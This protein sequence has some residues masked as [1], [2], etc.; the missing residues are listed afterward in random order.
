LEAGILGLT[1]PTGYQ[2]PAVIHEMPR[3][4]YQPLPYILVNQITLEQ[5]KTQIGQDFPS[6]QRTPAGTAIQTLAILARRTF[7]V[8]I[9]CR[10]AGERE[11]YRDAV[12]AILQSMLASVFQSLQ[13]DTNHSFIVHSDQMVGGDMDPGFYF[14]DILFKIEGIYNVTLQPSFNIIN[15]IVANVGLNAG[16]INNLVPAFS[17]PESITESILVAQSGLPDFTSPN[18]TNP[19]ELFTTTQTIPSSGYT[20]PAGDTLTIL[21]II[22][23][24]Y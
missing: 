1:L 12:L 19:V 11:F 8:E 22:D 5:S 16:F 24:G 3:A 20:I 17:L 18:T 7:R 9:F 6:T 14:S 15:N 4:G 10:T 13:L 23:N 2:R 21:P